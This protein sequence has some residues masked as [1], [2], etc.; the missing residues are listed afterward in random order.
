M[1]LNSYL[2]PR[3]AVV[4]LTGVIGVRLHARDF[5]HLLRQIRQNPRYKAVVLD[6][7]SP[8]GSAFA[9]EDIYVSA[10][11][12]AESKPVVSAIRG[13]GASGSYMVACA[14]ERIWALP[15]S[16]VG[17]IGVISARPLVE[18]L[19]GKLGV[20][21]LVAKSGRLKDMGS[22]FREPTEEE[23]VKE[24]ELLDAIY[25]RFLE[26]VAEGRPG[27]EAARL[28]ELATGEVYLGSRAE[29]LGLVDEL[30]G[31]D[32]AVAWAAERAG[33][34]ARTSVLRPR[35]SLAQLLFSRAANAL[36][37]SVAAA[38]LERAYTRALG[39]PRV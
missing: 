5:T 24:Q 7:D 21:M 18:E 28:R 3:V 39:V 37:D 13:V 16:I 15:S 14:G 22:V 32:D 11:K 33:I 12:L 30:G 9:S 2:P 10:R 4:E 8:G 38:A 19:L 29:E 27:L 25:G 31:L 36:V 1:D 17:S 23:R 34:P 35:R 6:I 26:I 20:E